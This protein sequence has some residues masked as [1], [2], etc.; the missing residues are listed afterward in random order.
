MKTVGITGGIGSG[1]TTC[2]KLFEELGIPVYYADTRAKQLMVS[3][4]PLKKQI[5]A[6]LGEEAYHRNGRPNRPYIA[7]KIF[8]D[9]QL[10]KKMNGL[11]H[12]AVGMD[13]IYWAQAQTSTYG[14]YEA[15][16]LVENGSYKNFDKL[17]VVTCPKEERIRRVMKR[18]NVS[19]EAVLARMKNQ[20][21]EK[22]KVTVGDFIIDNSGNQQLEAQIK[23][24]HDEL[25][26]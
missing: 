6:L 2:C 16:L 18:D 19:K 10:L 13:V 22:K 17:I 23:Q 7:S 3:N 21:P 14:L 12:P 5:K 4:K 20:L 26:C 24:I 11:V 1:K 15:A 25:M 9:K 8:S